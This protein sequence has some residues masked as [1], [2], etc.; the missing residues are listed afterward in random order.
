[1][2]ADRVET[3]RETSLGGRAHR[4]AVEAVLALPIGR[5]AGR[6]GAANSPAN[7]IKNTRYSPIT[8]SHTAIH[9]RY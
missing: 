8:D 7:N 6:I 3:F 2:R 5:K 1:M 4:R 9:G